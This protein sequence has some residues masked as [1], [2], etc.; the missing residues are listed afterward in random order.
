MRKFVLL[1][2]ICGCI[3]SGCTPKATEEAQASET[4]PKL[5]L[6]SDDPCAKFADSRAGQAAL[7]A[8]VIY[9]DYVKAQRFD[10]ALPYWREAFG[11]APAADGQRQTH[12]EDGIV[13]YDH[14]LRKS[15][16]EEGK[17]VYLDSIFMLYDRMGQCYHTDDR[18]YVAGRKA[19]D[20]YY[21]YRDFVSNEEVLGYF[22]TSLA[23]DGLD[24]QAFVVFNTRKEAVPVTFN[25][26]NTNL[27]SAWNFLVTS[28]K[29]DFR[30]SFSILGL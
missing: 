28:S 3:W 15:A 21:K 25:T 17:R 29:A 24:A 13:I 16:T 11:A 1:A 14:L 23:E 20:L 12:Y 6:T 4:K 30:V 2:A 5:P 26:D 18:G 9:R 22:K 7:D 27:K 19:F 8:H 10:E